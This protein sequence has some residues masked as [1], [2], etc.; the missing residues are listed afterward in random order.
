[1]SRGRRALLWVELLQAAEIDALDVAADAA[2]RERQRHPRLE[3]SD[4][5][6]A[7]RRDATYR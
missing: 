1:M 5:P 3:T 6:R 4:R 2:F 7:S